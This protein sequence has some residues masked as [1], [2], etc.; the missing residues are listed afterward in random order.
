MW[1]TLIIEP[2]VNVLL[3]IYSAVG[4]NFG[5]AIILFTI[6]I[7][8]ITHPLMVQQIKGASA[9]QNLQTNE[10]YIA[11]QKKYKDDKEKLAQ[12]Q[13]KLYQELGINPLA[14]CLPTLIQFPIIIGLYQAVIRALAVTP[15]QLAELSKHIY[16]FIDAAKLIPLNTQFLW[17]TNLSQP[18]RWYVFGFGVPTLAILVVV[19]TFFQQKLM[20]VPSATPNDPSAQTMQMM[21]I[22]MPLLMGYISYSLAAGLAVYFVVSN[23]V[24]VLQYAA[25]GR[26]NWSNILPA[27]LLPASLSA[28]P[29]KKK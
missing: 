5:L 29:T 17:M 8:L 6:L 20:A 12:E 18:E 11:L 4:G 10:K 13:M 23:V 19:T 28:K 1:D 7:R 9:M 22:Y 3:W 24:T 15:M 14:S 27:N 2:M 21:N 25:L 26:L 16:P